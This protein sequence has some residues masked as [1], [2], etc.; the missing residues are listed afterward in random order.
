MVNNYFSSN[1]HNEIIFHEFF[2]NESYTYISVTMYNYF[3]HKFIP[4]IKSFAFYY[5]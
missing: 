3:I 2:F 1:F 4:N 5:S